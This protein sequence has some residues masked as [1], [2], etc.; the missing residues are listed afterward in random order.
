MA[1]SR[2]VSKHARYDLASLI[3]GLYRR[4]AHRLNVDP[5]YVSRVARGQR[6]SDAVKTEL[7]R[8]LDRIVEH[9]SKQRRLP[10]TAPKKAQKAKRFR[11]RRVQ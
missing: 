11:L 5:S 4:V 9:F 10:R 2:K 8:E 6:H 7:R 1:K 3:R